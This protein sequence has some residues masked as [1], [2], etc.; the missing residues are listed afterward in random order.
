MGYYLAWRRNDN[1]THATAGMNLTDI[2]LREIGQTQKGKYCIY[3]IYNSIYMRYLEQPTSQG[4]KVERW[5]PRAGG[6][7]NGESWLNECRVSGM[8]KKFWK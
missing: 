3:N 8:M 6:R 2:M 4:Q 1:L 7:A 5:L